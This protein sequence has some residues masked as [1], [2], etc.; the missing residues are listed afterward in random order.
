VS[1]AALWASLTSAMSA[2]PC[3]TR[4]ARLTRAAAGR[5]GAHR[6]RAGQQ[7]PLPAAERPRARR[8]AAQAAEQ[9]MA[10]AAAADREASPDLHAPAPAPGDLAAAG[11]RL[12]RRA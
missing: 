7:V 2:L 1:V 10:A 5:A 3:P 4:P 11:A 6:A 9:A 8:R 12:Q